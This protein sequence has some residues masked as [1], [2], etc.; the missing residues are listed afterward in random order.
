MTPRARISSMTFWSTA[1]WWCS[2]SSLYRLVWCWSATDWWWR[3][4]RNPVLEEVQSHSSL[5]RNRWRWSLLSF[6]LSCCASCLSMWTAVYT[7]PSVTWTNTWAARCWRLP[8]WPTWSRDLWPAP[9]AASTPSS[10]SWQDRASETASRTRKENQDL[11]TGNHPRPLYSVLEEKRNVNV[12]GEGSHSGKRPVMNDCDQC[13]WN[14]K[15]KILKVAPN[16]E[17]F[18]VV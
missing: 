10:T 5:S 4:F 17:P 9:T 2:C 18:G 13:W 1:L 6:W 8:A 14:K 15:I 16:K 3:N 7:T 11:K 12:C